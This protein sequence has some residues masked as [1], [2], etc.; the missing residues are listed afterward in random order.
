MTP[1]EDKTN[2]INDG[3]T[4]NDLLFAH[5]DKE[6]QK[7]DGVNYEAKPV[8]K[9]WMVDIETMS[10]RDNAAII[11]IA[12]VPFCLE[13]MRILDGDFYSEC[14][15]W[16]QP[17]RHICADTLQFHIALHDDNGTKM[18]LQPFM[19]PTSVSLRDILTEFNSLFSQECDIWARG[20][21]DQR[22]ILNAMSEFSIKP[23]WIHWQWADQRTLTKLL[24]KQPDAPKATHH[25]LEDCIKQ[26]KDLFRV[27]KELRKPFQPQ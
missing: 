2:G 9:H 22:V 16:S 13:T 7:D 26:I 1:I 20:D 19:L 24:P 4:M 25:A 8:P 27:I 17:E 3:P 21:L 23:S 15:L 6:R 11:S 18:S 14:G 5:I 12:A 10:L